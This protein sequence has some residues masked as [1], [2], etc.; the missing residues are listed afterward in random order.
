MGGKLSRPITPRWVASPPAV[1]A[2][3]GEAGVGEMAL[4]QQEVARGRFG[5]RVVRAPVRLLDD[6]VLKAKQDCLQ[7]VDDLQQDLLLGPML[8]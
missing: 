5:L 6:M 2:A 1:M 3:G 8:S 4:S 7:S